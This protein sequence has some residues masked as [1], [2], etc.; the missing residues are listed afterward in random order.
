MNL[1]LR[2][3][4]EVWQHVTI[5]VNWRLEMK[6]HKIRPVDKL[7]AIHFGD[8]FVR[9]LNVDVRFGVSKQRNHMTFMQRLFGATQNAALHQDPRFLDQ[10]SVGDE[11]AVSEN[12]SA[13]WPVQSVE[14][15][16]FLLYRYLLRLDKKL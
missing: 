1:K 11:I 7:K 14:L 6:Q 9:T 16:W 8:L 3:G 5:K 15:F 4:Q 13:P 2:N 12:L 10:N